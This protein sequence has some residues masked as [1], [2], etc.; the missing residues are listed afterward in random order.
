MSSY[1]INKQSLIKITED[2]AKNLIPVTNHNSKEL[3]NAYFYT[4]IPEG[5][6]WDYIKYYTNR[7]VQHWRVGEY[8]GWIYILSNKTIPGLYK[9]GH[10]KNNVDE[11]AR[12]ISRATGVPV[13]FRV[14]WAFNCF[15]SELL[16]K[17]VHRALETFRF[18]S[19]REFFE[20]ELSKAKQ[21]ITEL[22]QVYK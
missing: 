3:E 16:E 18:A 12:E 15:D 5:D 21:V 13:P 9:I 17:E 6:G 22:G 11:R 20:V 10:T 4:L 2:E 19:N 7:P 14:E 8:N 1:K